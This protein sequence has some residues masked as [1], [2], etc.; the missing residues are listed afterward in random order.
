[1]KIET[2]NK[3]C[4]N[5]E[6]RTNIQKPFTISDYTYATDGHIAIRVEKIKS[7]GEKEDS[8][9]VDKCLPWDDKIEN[10]LPL[11]EYTVDISDNCSCCKGT[12]KSEECLECGGEGF[13][14]FETNFNYY[15]C[16]CK[17]CVGNGYILSK[18]KTCLPC[19][20]SGIKNDIPIYFKNI[21]LNMNLLE[22][23]KDLPNIKLGTPKGESDPIK[24]KFDGGDGFIMP[25]RA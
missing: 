19:R 10:W 7:I 3:F 21:K 17:T 20:G 23:I 18:N 8:I 1:M 2:L 9:N 11:P 4:S 6:I 13:L 25:M 12:K 5:D 24:I 22:R 15:E 16:E 14:E